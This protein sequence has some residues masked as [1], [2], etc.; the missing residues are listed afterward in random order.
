M[1]GFESI[2]ILRTVVEAHE[3][4]R[5]GQPGEISGQGVDW[6]IVSSAGEMISP[7]ALPCANKP[8]PE[9]AK[10]QPFDNN[11]EDPMSVTSYITLGQFHTAHLAALPRKMELNMMCPNTRLPPVPALLWLH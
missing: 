6:R 9:C 2:I 11:M 10:F 3:N 5:A 7:T 1:H 4:I 8:N